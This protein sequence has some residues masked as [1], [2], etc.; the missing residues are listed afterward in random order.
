MPRIGQ[1][2]SLDACQGQRTANEHT[3]DNTDYGDVPELRA[4]RFHR[5]EMNP[6]P[7][8]TEVVVECPFCGK[9]KLHINS[10][11]GLYDCKTCGEKGNPIEFLRTLH[12]YSVEDT[13][14]DDVSELCA[15]RGFIFNDTIEKWQVCKSIVSGEWLSPG[16]RT[17]GIVHN[18]YKWTEIA[19]GKRG[20]FAT[21]GFGHE[22]TGLHLWDDKK[23]TVIICEGLW[24]AMA[25]Y[26]VLARC[27]WE[28]DEGSKLVPTSNL[29]AS[30]LGDINVVATPGANVW[31]DS[32]L[33]LFKGKRVILAFDSDHPKKVRNQD[34]YTIPVGLAGMKRIA[35]SLVTASED[36]RPESVHWI[37]WGDDGYDPDLRN[38]T[39]VRDIL[40]GCGDEL[41]SRMDGVKYLWDRIEPIP[42]SWV[43]GVV[44]IGKNGV[45]EDSPI[46]CER[47]SALLN[48][49][50]KALSWK[51]ELEHGF[52]CM[53]A[54]VT[55]T[56]MVGDP[57]WIKLI[58]AA[59]S[60]KTVL[61]EALSLNRKYT[62]PVSTFK[63]LFSGFKTDAKGEEDHSLI[64]QL[65]NKTMIIK[66]GDTL[67]KSPDRDRLLSELRDMYDCKS[68]PQFRN[69]IDREYNQKTT[70]ILCGT[71][72][73]RQLDS[74]DLGAR[75][76]DVVMVEKIDKDMERDVLNRVFYDS[77]KSS[78]MKV[79]GT[80]ESREKPSVIEM[81]RMTS[82]YIHYLRENSTPL[83]DEVNESMVNDES[84]R[85]RL[86]DLSCFVSYI[87]ARPSLA[88]N[89][90][91][92][93]EL[94]SRVMAQL[95]RLAVYIAVVMNKR[96]VD[97]KVMYHVRK[98]AIDTSIGTTLTLAGYLY[99]AYLKGD[100]PCSIDDLYS[101]SGMSKKR[102]DMQAYMTFLTR[103]RVV[104]RVQVPIRDSRYFTTMYRL[105][106]EV[107]SLYECV[108]L[109]R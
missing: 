13:D 29:T 64:A 98:V 74:S 15:H 1:A 71:P 9:H 97:D 55:S 44:K 26:E 62:K 90:T 59:G 10:Q 20:L 14:G 67:L 102:F 25:L 30:L 23:S 94:P 109:Q 18:V 43:D 106:E 33:P 27:K 38:G 105:S 80:M 51:P 53:L 86:I 72:S 103:I 77:V 41:C 66:E 50:R 82:G 4:Y 39:D 84:V 49:C 73:I 34:R 85:N 60:G 78:G 11:T 76:I 93:R 88:Y 21:T 63:G 19:E 5:L 68:R 2:K 83:A 79:N 3:E 89:E 69:G 31:L 47:W 57:L 46:K 61:S 65:A 40:V 56:D 48:T 92:E 17:T 75:F 107:R 81:Q 22:L 87:R 16:Y 8:K 91:V 6:K 32:W 95:S 58:S 36:N 54:V 7:G 24:D 45:V 52:V 100:G 37:A 42:E 99:D 96:T 12:R 104:D 35:Q 70:I 28:D 108:I 101:L